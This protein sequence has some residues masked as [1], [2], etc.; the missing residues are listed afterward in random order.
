MVKKTVEHSDETL[1][2]TV[3]FIRTVSLNLKTN[4]KQ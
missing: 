1:D 2:A 4:G 3:D